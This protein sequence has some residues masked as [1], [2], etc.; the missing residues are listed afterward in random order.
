MIYQAGFH[1]REHFGIFLNDR[2]LT[3]QAVEVGTHLAE[4]ASTL[5]ES[6]RGDHLACIDPYISG[7]CE[8]DPI[9]ERTS[10]VRKSD[11]AR[12][13]DRLSQYLLSG[14]AS[15][16]VTES[17]NAVQHERF[18]SGLDFVYLDGNHELRAFA[19][20]LR[21]WWP[22]VKSG[23]LLAG[24]DIICPGEVN[25]GWGRFIQPALVEHCKSERIR[26][27]FLV[28]E[29]RGAWSWYIVKP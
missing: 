1:G 27:V 8:G 18:D 20:D 29:A 16:L 10:S 28:T 2:S 3:G 4:F 26:E 19:E 15:I 11:Y 21:L 5:L 17:C 12:A 24:H 23:G 9:S 13:K 22:K 6:W 7:Y 14:R 25:G